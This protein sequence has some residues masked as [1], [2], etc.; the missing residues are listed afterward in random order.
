VEKV[1]NRLFK[2]NVCLQSLREP[3]WAERRREKKNGPSLKKSNTA[4]LGGDAAISVV[5]AERGWVSKKNER[6]GKEHQKGG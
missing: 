3:P 2:V 5:L 4:E 1:K 6:K